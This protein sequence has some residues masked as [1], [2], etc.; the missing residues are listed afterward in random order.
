MWPCCLEEFNAADSASAAEVVGLWA[1][2]PEWV[3]AI[4][5]ARPYGSVDELAD[6]HRRVAGEWT[7]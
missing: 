3:D 1:A 6:P 5:A 7:H 4:V 2:I